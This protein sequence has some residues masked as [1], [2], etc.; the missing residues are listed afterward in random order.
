[1]ILFVLQYFRFTVT[2]AALS[3]R[4]TARPENAIRVKAPLVGSVL[5]YGLGTL[6]VCE[7]GKSCFSAC[8]YLSILAGRYLF[9]SLLGYPRIDVSTIRHHTRIHKLHIQ[10]HWKWVR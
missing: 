2:R 10:A 8:C 9:E 7:E 3:C 4:Q 6:K 1:M 5:P